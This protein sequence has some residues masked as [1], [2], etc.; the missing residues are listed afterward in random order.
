VTLPRLLITGAG[1]LL[2]HALCEAAVHRW[3]VFA[4]GRQTV[5]DVAQIQWVPADITD[6][7]RLGDVFDTVRPQAVIHAAAMSQPNACEQSPKASAAV[8][9]EATIRIG[10]CCAAAGIP[11]VFTS[12]DLVFDG[13]H[14][15]YEESDPV[16]PI[17]VY[18]RHKAAAEMQLRAAN[19]GATI[20]RLPLMFGYAPTGGGFLGELVHTLS[21]GGRPALFTDEIRTPVS[22]RTAAQGLLAMLREPGL[23][24]HMGGRQS[25]SRYQFGLYVATAMKLPAARI[26]PIR[27]G[28]LTMPAPRSPDVSLNS[29]RAERLGFDA[30]DFIETLQD[31]IARYDG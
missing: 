2:G 1:G 14:P 29:R 9:L 26:A 12:S 13:T 4:L 20:C 16:S 6:D 8:N 28:E 21:T 5:P 31:A 10:A 22:T 7:R 17:S 23:T 3:S 18:G 15:P 27:L 19:P 24:V 11:L 25:I 30:G